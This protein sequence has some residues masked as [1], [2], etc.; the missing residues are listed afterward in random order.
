MEILDEYF[1]SSTKTM[2]ASATHTAKELPRRLSSQA[3]WDKQYLRA[4]EP[5]PRRRPRLWGWLPARLRMG[6]A[7][8]I[9]WDVILPRW[10][11]MPQGSKIVEIGSAPGR[12]LLQ[13]HHQFGFVPYGIEYAPNG[14][15]AN[16]ELFQSNGLDQENV[17]HAD[18]FSD[19]V[20]SR[21]RGYFDIVF[22]AGFV[23]HFTDVRGVV[24]RHVELLAPSGFLAVIAPNLRGLNKWLTK[25]SCPEVLP[26][27][28]LNI[29]KV[30]AWNSLFDITGLQKLY[31]GYFGTIDLCIVDGLHSR[32]GSGFLV[33]LRQVQMLFNIALNWLCS[34][35]GIESGAISP[36]LIYIGRKAG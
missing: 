20:L 36:F 34:S 25:L 17:L 29:M 31:C 35:G 12:N 30:R 24:E 6:Y 15:I 7:N 9:L 32:M 33:M 28:N 16:R 2:R 19:E 23:E 18:F 21:Y 1:R 8:H 11:T 22:S 26:L 13:F 4:S 27:H 10:I 3:Y 14:V 5:S